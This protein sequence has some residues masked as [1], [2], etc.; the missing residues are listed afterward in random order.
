VDF[1]FCEAKYELPP[2]GNNSSG[3][4]RKLLKVLREHKCLVQPV[5][6]HVCLQ[7]I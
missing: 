5:L 4:L 6:F 7:Q 1:G 2:T 3:Y